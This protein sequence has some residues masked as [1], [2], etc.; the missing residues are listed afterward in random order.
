M[1]P[2]LSIQWYPCSYLGYCIYPQL[3]GLPNALAVS[4]SFPHLCSSPP[5]RFLHSSQNYLSKTNYIFWLLKSLQLICIA[6]GISRGSC[7]ISSLIL[8]SPLPLLC[9]F[10][11]FMQQRLWL[12]GQAQVGGYLCVCRAPQVTPMWTHPQPPCTHTLLLQV[13]QR[14]TS[15]CSQSHR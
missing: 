6:C 12:K 1:S 11:S 13:T 5:M 10:S 7:V 2:L 9:S 14:G 8:N 3:T 4:S 15:S